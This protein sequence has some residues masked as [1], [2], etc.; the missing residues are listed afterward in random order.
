MV[1]FKIQF[2]WPLVLTR[3]FTRRVRFLDPSFLRLNG[4]TRPFDLTAECFEGEISSIP[5]LLDQLIRF[6]Q[7]SLSQYHFGILYFYFELHGI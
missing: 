7:A 4:A 5:A 3:V 2:V 1:D 6:R